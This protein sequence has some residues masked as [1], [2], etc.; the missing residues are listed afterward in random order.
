MRP[1]S[2]NIDRVDV[3]FDEPSLVASAGLVTVAT[4]AVRLGLERLIDQTV[5]L[6][7]GVG[8]ANAGS[9]VLTLVHVLVAGGSHTRRRDRRS[10]LVRLC[11]RAGPT[12]TRTQDC[13]HDRA[14]HPPRRIPSLFPDWRHHVFVTNRPETVAFSRPRAPTSVTVLSSRDQAPQVAAVRRLRP[15][16][17]D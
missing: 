1:V 15:A 7:G 9:K 5:R 10:R 2:H 12:R 16:P 3:V 11:Q 14:P 6:V 4:L 17:V 8:G 13:P